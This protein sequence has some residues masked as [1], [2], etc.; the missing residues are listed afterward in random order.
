MKR[1][2]QE[3]QKIVNEVK[4]QLKFFNNLQGQTYSFWSK[5][6]YNYHHLSVAQI[7]PLKITQ[8]KEMVTIVISKINSPV[9]T[10]NYHL[11]FKKL[12]KNERGIVEDSII[13]KRRLTEKDNNMKKFQRSRV[14]NQTNEIKYNYQYFIKQYERF[15]GQIWDLT[16]YQKQSLKKIRQPYEQFLV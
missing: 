16:K 9:S 13:Q 14:Q 8:K 2:T 11:S 10:K 4:G 7:Q 1:Q 3:K 5:Q 12:Q 6:L 15:F